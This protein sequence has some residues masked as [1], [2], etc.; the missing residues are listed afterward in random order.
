MKRPL[1]I[2]AIAVACL[3]ASSAAAEEFTVRGVGFA[4][5]KGNRPEAVRALATQDA[6]RHAVIAAIDKM[7]GADA[8]AK[9]E[10][11]Q[12][13]GAIV[14]QVANSSVVDTSS[15]AV[16]DRFEV[17]LS[18]ALDD[19]GFRELLSDEG[20]ALNTSTTRSYSILAV[21]DEYRTTPKDL[22][23]PVED[24]VE[25]NSQVGSSFSDRS[26]AGSSSRAAAARASSAAYNVDAKDSSSG[27][28]SG[29]YSGHVSA[30][31]SDQ[32]GSAGLGA[33]ERAR[34]AAQQSSSS[35]IR[36]SGA[37][38]SAATSSR[39]ASSFDRTNVQ[40]EDHDNVSYRRLVK[41][42]P[43][44]TAPETL[45]RTYGALIG[46]LQAYDLRIIDNDVFRSKYFR[47]KPLTLDKIVNGA[48]LSRY[49]GYA[50]T[51]SNADFFL[52]GTSVIIDS[53]ISPT[54]GR[55]IC[56]GIVTLKVY[57]TVDGE[58]IAAETIPE[59][60]SGLN[61]DDCAGAV[62]QKLAASIGPRVGAQI[63][64][65]WKRRQMY[66]RE[67]VL[68]LRGP[69]SLG[70]RARFASA[71]ATLP[72]V[73]NSVQRS[74]SGSE[75]EFTIS[76]KGGAPID[77]ALAGALASDPTFAALDSR[78]EAGRVLMC[79]GPCPVGGD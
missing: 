35:S 38:A 20:V 8:S 18:L 19:R 25:F 79:L 32:S 70:V 21:M 63:Q 49:V 53:G 52:A 7:L 78:S 51:D 54:T 1:A 66:G 72:G 39:S 31:G 17:T 22:Q 14:D 50:K 65:Y 48:E 77:Q 69:L 29:S 9:P 4:P 41:Y 34:L 15:E 43:Q 12:K 56:S 28:V 24:L 64:T 73:E 30:A 62:T 5:I 37:A 57:S 44:A 61:T 74:A 55:Y 71:I 26:S 67:L 36:G 60:G 13:I 68:T 16:G 33:S 75:M 47:D 10:I 76:Y 2:G 59:T 3:L 27:S 42:Q 23:A 45:N 6:K 11:A 46:Q 58:T 40:A